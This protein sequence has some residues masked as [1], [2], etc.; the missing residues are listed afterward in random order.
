MKKNTHKTL[1]LITAAVALLIFVLMFF[2]PTVQSKS[3]IH[4]QPTIGDS[5]ASIQM[6]VFEEMKCP[7]CKTFMEY[8]Y[9]VLKEK[10]IHTGEMQLTLIPLSFIPGSQLAAQAAICVFY[11]DPS[12]IFPFFEVM[13]RHASVEEEWVN[14]D[15]MV[16]YASLTGGIDLSGFRTCVKEKLFSDELQKNYDLAKEWMDKVETP[17]VFINGK[18]IEPPTLKQLSLVIEEARRGKR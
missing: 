6:V 5:S 11:L 15:N 12:Q 18:R 8:I 14:F 2:I 16:K 7:H 9:P 10:Y 3:P 1:V 17:A 4:G 13:F